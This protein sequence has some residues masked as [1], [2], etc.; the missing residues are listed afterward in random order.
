MAAINEALEDFESRDYPGRIPYAQ[1]ARKYGVVPSTLRRRHLA[2]TEPR[3]VSNTRRQLLT[4]NKSMS[5]SD[6]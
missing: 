2:E 6:G 3:S 1:V 4:L 5:L